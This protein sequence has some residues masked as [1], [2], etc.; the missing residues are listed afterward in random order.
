[1]WLTTGATSSSV[2]F[3]RAGAVAMN[4]LT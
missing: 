2:H 4:P 3:P 1:V